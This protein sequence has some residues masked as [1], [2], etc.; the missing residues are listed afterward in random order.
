MNVF[1][2][3]LSDTQRDLVGAIR[4]VC[5]DFDDEYWSRHDTDHEFPH[6]FYDAM[7]KLGIVGMMA[8]PEYGGGGSTVE[9]AALALQEI[10]ASGAGINGCS[11]VHLSMFGFHPVT[12]WGSPALRAKYLPRVSSGEIHVSFSVT[13][14]DAG[15]D[16]TR[17]TTR[18]IPTD[19]GWVLRGRK[20]WMT[21]GLQSSSALVL[22]RTAPLGQTT[23]PVDGLSLFVVDLDPAHVDI[24]PIPKMGRNAVASCEVVFDDLPI[25]RENLVGEEGRGF[26]NLLDGLNPERI[27][28]AAEAVGL[29]IAALRRATEYARDRVVFG[30]PIGQNQGIQHP[31]ADA[32]MQLLAA[33][34]LTRVAARLYDSGR[35]CGTEANTAKFL[36]ARAACF[37]A[38]RAVQTHGGMGYATEYHVERYFREARM[39]RI[40]PVTE[41]QIMN[42]V[43]ERALKLPKSY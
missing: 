23:R 9:D 11:T 42:Y 33:A 15:S 24:R 25:P 7:V 39:L 28:V 43:A 8:E 21:K 19:D 31:L 38:D 22:A 27:L 17:I 6:D 16:T 4:S 37:A 2:L 5:A 12:K 41:E 3:D 14:P 29:G 18:A 26:Y 30:R 36:A 13:E 34:H 1:D 20:V 35:P 32:H 40:T 10:A